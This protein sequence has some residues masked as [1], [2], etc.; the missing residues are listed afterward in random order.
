MEGAF[1]DGLRQVE[2]VSAEEVD[3]LEKEQRDPV[4]V[5]IAD[6]PSLMS[7]LIDCRLNIGRIP[8]GDDRTMTAEW[9]A[10]LAA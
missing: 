4:D 2:G 3:V 6:V 1:S 9:I 8:Q 5:S 7:E 10:A